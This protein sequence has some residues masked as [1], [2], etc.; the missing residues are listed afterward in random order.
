MSIKRIALFAALTMSVQ[1]AN[2]Q[3]ND[4]GI[5]AGLTPARAVPLTFLDSIFHHWLCFLR[6]QS[7]TLKS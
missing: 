1:M 3:Y 2:A 5:S 6:T 7:Q 4:S